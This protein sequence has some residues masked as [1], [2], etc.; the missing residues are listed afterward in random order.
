M[1]IGPK[2]VLNK[3]NNFFKS[4]KNFFCLDSSKYLLIKFFY[5]IVYFLVSLQ[6]NFSNYKKKNNVKNQTKKRNSTKNLGKFHLF[7]NSEISA[8]YF[9]LFFIKY[10]TFC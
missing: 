5:T 2:I 3:Q 7:L 9:A 4:Q 10:N 1:P 6:K 8:M